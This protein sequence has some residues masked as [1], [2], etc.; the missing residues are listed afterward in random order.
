GTFSIS[1]TLD[2]SG[3]SAIHNACVYDGGLL[4]V[5]SGNLVVDGTL[6]GNAQIVGTSML[7]LADSAQGA[8]C[9]ATIAF[10][11]GAH[12]TLKLDSAAMFDGTVTGFDDDDRIDLSHVCYDKYITTT[13]ANGVLTVFDR[14]SE[15]AH[16]KLSGDNSGAHFVAVDDGHGGTVIEE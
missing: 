2:S 9:H 8:Y 16:I 13:Y 3:C 12:G 6:S 1:G 5:N 14:G 11:T 15:V 10:A 4:Q 7:E